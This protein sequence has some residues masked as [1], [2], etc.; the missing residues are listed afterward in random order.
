LARRTDPREI[1]WSRQI[2]AGDAYNMAC[3]SRT[4]TNCPNAKGPDYDF[5]SSAILVDLSDARR[6]LV[7]A[8]KSGVVT[9]LDPDRRGQALWQKR[10]GGGGALGGIEW[11]AAADTNNVYIAVSDV[12]PRVVPDGT[13]GSQKSF[14]APSFLLNSKMGG[15]LYALKLETGEQVWHAP[16]RGCNGVPGCSPAQSAAV[17]VIPGTV[18]SG[19]L[20]GQSSRLF[21]PRRQ[22]HLGR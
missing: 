1:A 8:Q 10:V 20:D 7:G 2:T 15:S 17:T 5:G 13:P 21:A 3:G 22:D 9:A 18:F 4:P 19:G 6:A 12:L 16:H 14:V 11:G